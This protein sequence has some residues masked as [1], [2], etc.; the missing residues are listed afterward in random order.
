MRLN[1]FKAG[2]LL[3]GLAAL[4]GC[5]IDGTLTVN[6]SANL[7]DKKGRAVPIVAGQSYRTELGKDGDKVKLNIEIAGKEREI[8]LSPPP[9]TKLPKYAGELLIPAARSGQPVDFHGVIDTQDSDGSDLRGSQSCTTT[10]QIRV[11]SQVPVPTPAGAPARTEERC[12]FESR[13][14]TGNQEIEYHDR[15]TTTTADVRLLL[16]NT[17]SV[18]ATFSG[19]RSSSQQIITWSGRCETPYDGGPGGH[20]G[21]DRDRR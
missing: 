12:S 14:V 5:D 9:G 10:A 1:T 3:L 19:S 15:T 2:L 17:Q 18:V 7:V 21:W 6:Q 16:P 8:R 13:S 20:G 11:C 4:T